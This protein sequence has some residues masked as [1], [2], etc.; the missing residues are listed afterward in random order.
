MLEQAIQ[1]VAKNGGITVAIPTGVISSIVTVA[2]IKGSDLILGRMRGKARSGNG[3]PKPGTGDE[4]LKHR[5]KLT[6]HETKFDALDT[7]LTRYEGYFQNILERL[8]K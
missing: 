8:P 3:G 6:E 5:D 2:I 1:E 7:T 4:C